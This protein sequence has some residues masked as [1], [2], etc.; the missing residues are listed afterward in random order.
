MSNSGFSVHRI[1]HAKIL[2]WVAISFSRVSSKP[3]DGNPC[4]PH[5]QGDIFLTTKPPGIDCCCIES[6][7]VVSSSWQPHVPYSPWNS[8]GL[9]TGVGSLSLLQ[10]IFPTQGSNSGLPH[11]RQILYQL[12]Y[13]RS[14]LNKKLLTNLLSK[15][16]CCGSGSVKIFL[17]LVLILWERVW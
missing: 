12:S 8:L 5:W 10:G 7:S 16:V 17:L 2:E 14:P 3:R 6:C 13:Q 9:D 4:L 11:C 1:S 15:D